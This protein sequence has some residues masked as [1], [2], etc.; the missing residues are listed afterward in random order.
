[1]MYQVG[2]PP[3]VSAL[4]NG[5]AKTCEPAPP[6]RRPSTLPPPARVRIEEGQMPD[7]SLPPTR[8]TR[9]ATFSAQFFSSQTWTGRSCSCQDQSKLAMQKSTDGGTLILPTREQRH[10][11]KGQRNDDGTQ[12][13][14]LLGSSRHCLRARL[15]IGSLGLVLSVVACCTACGRFCI[16][17][18]ID[19]TLYHL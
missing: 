16:P 12:P 18:P 1:M 3:D 9:R 2:E 11:A 17:P 13:A 14:P 7:S 19:G 8:S 4:V 5:C 6:V 10:L 15:F